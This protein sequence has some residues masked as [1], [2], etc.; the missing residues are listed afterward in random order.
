MKEYLEY[1]YSQIPE[2]QFIIANKVILEGINLPISS[3]FVLNGK[4]FNYIYINI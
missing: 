1:K 4:H 2:L 3:L